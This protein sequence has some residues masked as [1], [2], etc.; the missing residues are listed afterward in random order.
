MAEK[1]GWKRWRLAAGIGGMACMPAGSYVLFAG[2]TG[3]LATGTPTCAAGN[4]L[5]MAAPDGGVFAVTGRSRAA[6]PAVS[7]LLYALSLGETFV[8][9]FRGRPI[10]LADFLAVR[11][12][13]TVAGSYVYTVSRE[14]ILSGLCLLALNAGLFFLSG[15]PALV[16]GAPGGCRGHSGGCDGG[17]SVADPGPGGL[18]AVWHR[19]VG[20][21][22]L[23]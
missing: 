2:G 15:A 4:I 10:M 18:R 5:L 6:V 17:L 9:E 7:L 1:T 13:M 8:M 11:T 3:N 12:A 20:Y 19:H 16:E 14:M 22:L 23:L 21:E